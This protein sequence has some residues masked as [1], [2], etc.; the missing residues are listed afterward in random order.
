MTYLHFFTNAS[1]TLRLVEHL[2]GQ[3]GFPLHTLTVIHQLDGWVL[4]VRLYRPLSIQE[5]GDFRA[6]LQEYGRPFKPNFHLEQALQGLNAGFS[7]VEVMRR[8]QIAIVSHGRP[9]C[10]EIEE[11][12]R[13]FV[14]GL[15][16]C[17][18][19]LG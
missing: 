19:T 18:E 14:R 11:F 16:Y 6:M 13:Q 17:P 9:D 2:A 1:F 15:G 7:P 10:S 8:F 12:R 4:Q 5:T 3:P